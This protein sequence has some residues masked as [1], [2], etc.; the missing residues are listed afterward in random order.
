MNLSSNALGVA[1]DPHRAIVPIIKQDH[2]ANVALLGTGLFIA[3]NALV[4]TAKHAARDFVDRAERATHS[5]GIFHFL[6]DNQY[7]LQPFIYGT[8]EPQLFARAQLWN[9]YFMVATA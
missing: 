3:Q 7:L 2:D 8:E 5:I 4:A 1:T 9:I 6:G